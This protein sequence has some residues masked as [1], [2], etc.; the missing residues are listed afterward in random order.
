MILVKTRAVDS[1]QNNPLQ[2][3]DQRSG[4]RRP[5]DF[6]IDS[7]T[8]PACT[9]LQAIK[10]ER[11]HDNATKDRGSAVSLEELDRRNGYPTN[12]ARSQAFRKPPTNLSDLPHEILVFVVSYL[13][14]GTASFISTTC[15]RLYFAYKELH[16]S[17]K[18]LLSE[19][20]YNSS[21][22]HHAYLSDMLESWMNSHYRRKTWRLSAPS[23]PDPS[24]AP[25]QYL[26]RDIYGS[27][28]GTYGDKFWK[29]ENDLFERYSDYHVYE[30]RNETTGKREKILPH[31]FNRGERWC[32]E[33]KEAVFADARTREAWQSWLEF[34]KE[35]SI[36]QKISYIEKLKVLQRLEGPPGSFSVLENIRLVTKGW[37][38]RKRKAFLYWVCDLP[39]MTTLPDPMDWEFRATNRNFWTLKH[40]RKR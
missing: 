5:V 36:F 11:P 8:S 12:E 16:P 39:D 14:L 9:C 21:G 31:P 27:T 34:W 18:V 10:S 33:A 37:L 24:W 2:S 28:E 15:T 6:C 25:P 20:C 4:K 1:E 17:T 7:P 29:K 35:S 26:R 3:S 30:R 22:M 19:R 40:V 38:R 32:R 23:L 13:D